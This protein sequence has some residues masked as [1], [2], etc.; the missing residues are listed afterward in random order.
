MRR[1]D[2]L[3]H[4]VGLRADRGRGG[5]DIFADRAGGKS[6]KERI[7]TAEEIIARPPEIIIGS[8]CGKKFRS[9]KVAVRPDFEQIPAGRR[10]LPDQVANHPATGP[11]CADGWITRTSADTAWWSRRRRSSAGRRSAALR[12]GAA[13]S[14]GLCRRRGVDSGIDESGVS[15][16]TQSDGT[17]PTAMPA[18]CDQ[19][20]GRVYNG[21][22]LLSPASRS[23]AAEAEKSLWN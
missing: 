21:C 16:V 9:E 7:V 8:W 14:R 11:G 12:P 3:R 19:L 6:A 10:S 13:R 2:D 1:A 22:D 20:R 23:D 4:H 5:T 17:Q 15:I 18:V